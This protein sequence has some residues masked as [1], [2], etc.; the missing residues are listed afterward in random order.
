MAS[1]TL[2]IAIYLIRKAQIALLITEKVTVLVEYSN[3]SNVLSKKS[4]KM[5][6]EQTDINEHNIKLE[7]T[8]QP[9]YELIYNLGPVELEILKIYIEINLANGFIRPSKLPINA[10]IF[11]FKSLIV[12]FICV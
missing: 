3:Y 9:P 7:K 1:L 5:L 11:F 4:A 10:L 12:V 8:K 6:P 2:K